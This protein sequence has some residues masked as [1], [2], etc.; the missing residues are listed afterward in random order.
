MR[1]IDLFAGLGGFHL[2]A[3]QLGLECVFA[4]DINNEL[5]DLYEQNFDFTPHGDI[6]Q[7]IEEELDTIPEHDLL[8]AGFPCQPFSKAGEQKGLRDKSRGQLFYSIHRILKHRKP[9]YFILENVANFVKHDNGRTYE[10]IKKELEDLDYEVDV[11]KLSPHH[12]GIPQI[13]ERIYIVGCKFGLDRFTW[14]QK[15]NNTKMSIHEI[16]DKNPSDAIPLAPKKI[17][18]LQV[19]Q[20]FINSYPKDENLPSFPVWSMEFKANYPIDMGSLQSIGLNRLQNR[21]GSFG[22]RL[23]DTD[24]REI[25]ENLPPYAR[26]PNPFPRWKQRFIEQNREL[27]LRNQLW[28]DNWLPS[29]KKFPPSLQKLEW[30]CKGEERNIWNYIIQ[31]RASGVRVKRT[32]TSPSLVAM[33]GTQI[34]VI[35]WEQRHMT[36]TECARLQCMHG[37]RHLPQGST[38]VTALGNAVNVTVVKNI[39]EQLIK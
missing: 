13:R 3:S 4:C 38:A 23:S 27:Y 39:L 8:C 34:P 7:V 25:L 22:K 18:C 2:A 11:C 17:E 35:A 32:T 21:K 26:G 5:R 31:F 19:W 15:S 24:R 10:T 12:F 37:L 29:I 9:T 36:V 28:L 20:D 6:R 33:T 30:N 14:P 1:F 16:L